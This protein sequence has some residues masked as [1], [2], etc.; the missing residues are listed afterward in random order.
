[1]KYLKRDLDK[2]GDLTLKK[3]DEL[4]DYIEV[5][6]DNYKNKNE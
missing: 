5:K 6:Y 1:M 3:W 2:A 4:N